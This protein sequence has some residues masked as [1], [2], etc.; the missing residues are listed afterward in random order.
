MFKEIYPLS[1]YDPALII[2]QFYVY[3]YFSKILWASNE[4]F[5]WLGQDQP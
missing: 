3:I 1:K 2:H 4:Y 5:I